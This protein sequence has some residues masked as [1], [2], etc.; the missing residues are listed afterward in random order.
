[1]PGV[2]NTVEV[3]ESTSQKIVAGIEAR[4]HLFLI[5]FTAIYALC[6]IG[7]ANGKPF[8]Y[9]EIIT[10]IAARA[11]HLGPVWN[12]AMETDAN[13]PLP[14]LLIHFSIRWFGLNEVTAR[15]P[16]LVGFWIF[17]MCL[18]LFVARRRGAVWGFCALLMPTLT[19]AYHYAAEARG[20][21]PELGFGGLALIA[22]QSATEKR[23][24]A[25]ALCGLSLSL[26]AML[27]CHYYAVL[28]YLPLA[29]AEAIRARRM[30]RLDWGVCLALALGSAPLIWRASQIA[31]VM[32]VNTHTWAQAY[33]RQGLEFWETGLAPGAA[34]AVLLAG[35]LALLARRA[36]EDP[37]DHPIPA[38]EWAA[39]VLLAAIPLVGVIGAL[40]VTHIFNER[41]V[42]I[43]LAGF[44]LLVPMLAA[45]F[46]GSR[47]AGALVML[48]VLAWGMGIRSLDHPYDGNPF[49]G[50]PVLR[51]ALERGPVVIPDGQ[52]FLQMW[53][54]AP[55]RYKSSLI[56]PVDNA[57]A[58]K[59]MGYDTIDGGVRLLRP[60]AAVNVVEWADFVRDTREFMAYQTS[61]RPGWVLARVVAE[62]ATVEVR[63]TALLRELVNVRLDARH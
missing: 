24:R 23:H 35:L 53:Y 34:F 46:I 31:G 22:W 63:K 2:Y 8:W 42:L 14:H 59:Y 40:L 44:C 21:G 13:P 38:H 37:Q 47:S 52:L 48:G 54:Y 36:Q 30:R 4:R 3:P 18:Y 1:L 55:E 29:G 25:A 16:S 43:G 57:A 26:A 20:Y 60:W 62:G 39:A 15:L 11:P 10:L 49:D 41:Y 7:R 19:R 33:L 12:A 58:V 45:E 51:E 17:C 6:A 32:N 50:E 28:I 9:D 61:L 5:L 27:M 56:F